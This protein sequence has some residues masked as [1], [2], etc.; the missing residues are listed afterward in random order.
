MMH[1]GQPTLAASI[2]ILVSGASAAERP[3][4]AFIL[5]GQSNPVGRGDGTKPSNDLREG[6]DR[7]LMFEDGK[8]PRPRPRAPANRGQK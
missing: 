7:V 8:W 3:I 4:Q 1:L 6:N 5:A 2:T